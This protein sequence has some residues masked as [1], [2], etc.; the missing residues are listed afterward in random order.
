MKKIKLAK[1]FQ[2]FIAFHNRSIKII[3]GTKSEN[4]I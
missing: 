3:H 4:F 1:I 2:G